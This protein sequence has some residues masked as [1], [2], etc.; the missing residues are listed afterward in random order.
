MVFYDTWRGMNEVLWLPNFL[1]MLV[2][3]PLIMVGLATHMVDL[4][5]GIC[6]TT[7]DSPLC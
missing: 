6:S 2:G 1:L 5:L 3:S 7:S 4:D